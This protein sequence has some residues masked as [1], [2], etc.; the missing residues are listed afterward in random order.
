MGTDVTIIANPTIDFSSNDFN[1]IAEKIKN[2]L[3]NTIIKNRTE[4]QSLVS[5]YYDWQGYEEE[6]RN[7]WHKEIDGWQDNAWHY[8]IENDYDN[9]I[10]IYFYSPFHFEDIK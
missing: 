5:G 7:N 1:S 3:D 4:I 10:Q 6:L 2:L 9:Y 8:A